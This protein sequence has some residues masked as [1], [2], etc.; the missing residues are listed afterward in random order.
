MTV[1]DLSVRVS[2]SIVK[3]KTYSIPHNRNTDRKK[4][5]IRARPVDSLS[6]AC[7]LTVVGYK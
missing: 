6:V 3:T 2:E 1:A 7:L 4:C 5:H